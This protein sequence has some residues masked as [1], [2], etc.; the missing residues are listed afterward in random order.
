MPRPEIVLGDR[1]GVSASARISKAV[2]DSIMAEG[3]RLRRNSPFAG[4]YIAATY[5]QPDRNIHALQLEMDRSLYMDE[6]RIQPRP[7]FD[8]FAT[9]FVRLVRRLIQIRPDGQEMPVAAE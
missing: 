9:R 6:R 2:G 3:F 4:A 5:G 8:R 1:N 7:D